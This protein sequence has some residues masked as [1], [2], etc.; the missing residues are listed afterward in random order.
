MNVKNEENCWEKPELKKHEIKDETKGG[1]GTATT[2]G[3]F[4]T[5]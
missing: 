5:S 1:T 3:D 4:I 2:D